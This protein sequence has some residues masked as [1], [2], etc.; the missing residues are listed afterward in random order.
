MTGKKLNF[1]LTNH[2]TLYWSIVGQKAPLRPENIAH[3]PYIE[4]AKRQ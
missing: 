1:Y 2:F 4:I 3:A